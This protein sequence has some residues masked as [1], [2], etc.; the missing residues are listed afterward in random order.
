MADDQ[1]MEAVRAAVAEESPSPVSSSQMVEEPIAGVAEET[2]EAPE[3]SQDRQEKV[4]QAPPRGLIRKIDKLTRRAKLAETESR[5]WKEKALAQGSVELSD[6]LPSG[7]WARAFRS[8][9][10]SRDGNGP[11]FVHLAASDGEPAEPSPKGERS[12]PESS[13][14]ENEASYQERTANFLAQH[15]DFDQVVNQISLRTDLGPAVEQA[16]MEDE[17]GPALAYYLGQH[18]E[19]CDELNG[20]ESEAALE[21]IAEKA[22]EIAPKELT[23]EDKQHFG[24]H[25]KLIRDLGR[26]F[27]TDPEFAQAGRAIN[28]VG[29]HPALVDFVSHVLADM[30]N[31]LEVFKALGKNPGLLR[32]MGQMHPPQ[33]GALLE[34]ISAELGGGDE[35]ESGDVESQAK[36]AA[37]APAPI[38]PIKR[39]SPTARGDL[40]DDLPPAEW[41]RRFKKKMGY[42]D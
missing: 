17:N 2:T 4:R 33:A 8:R 15:Q 29:A 41:N 27:V 42:G 37:V 21:R 22:A 26:K 11:S 40:H 6:D 23:E 7:E 14:E 30:P 10:A 9:M 35:V 24:A 12:Q 25:D 34:D 1:L 16:I 32:V 18:P 3:P 39:T 31:G 36:R 13:E 38:N 5:F 19:L 28:E 20:M